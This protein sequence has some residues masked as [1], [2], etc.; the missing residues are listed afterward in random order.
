[1]QG[2]VYKYF[3]VNALYSFGRAL[4]Q[5]ILT[6]L[7]LGKG[8]TLSDI[9]LIQVVYFAVNLVA[10]VP[11]GILADRISRRWVYLVSII[12]IGVSYATVLFASGLTWMMF[13]W[14]LYG[15]SAALVS[16]TMDTHFF[17]EFR[18]N[19]T[20]LGKFYSKDRNV[21][22]AVSALTAVL[23]PLLFESIGDHL[24][25]ISLLTFVAA[26]LCGLFL[27]P[28]PDA[29]QATE[30]PNHG[31]WGSIRNEL[32]SAITNKSVL[33]A[34]VVVASAELA[35]T[36]FFQLWQ[37]VLLDSAVSVAWFGAFFIC[38]QVM[39]MLANQIVSRF[40]GRPKVRGIAIAG[41]TVMGLV[42]MIFPGTVASVAALL[43]LPVPLFVFI[44][45]VE[46]RLQ[47][48]IPANTMSSVRSVGGV[49]E[50]LVAIG[51]LGI[52]SVMLIT[53]P[54]SLVLSCW[55]VAFAFIVIL[56]ARLAPKPS[57][58]LPQHRSTAG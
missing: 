14:A 22:L 11:S 54:P 1:M 4:P 50:S 3:A 31:G 28:K 42:L 56:L 39:N 13:A 33:Y 19:P 55:L 51:V 48:V 38:S 30:N 26:F 9:V 7:L 16:S 40:A 24:Y 47:Q 25:W 21:S 27:L 43:I 46:I 15:L 36:P 5:A 52:S 6:P 17:L 34:I 18:D 53:L 2:K 29:T 45:D 41:V 49:A 32:Q 44:G 10:E 57:S 8:L 58:H 23:S 20:L 35:V 37:M 12:F